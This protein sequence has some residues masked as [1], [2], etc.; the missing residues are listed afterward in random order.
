M[1]HTDI[2]TAGRRGGTTA[3]VSALKKKKIKQQ[4]APRLVNTRV[5][6]HEIRCP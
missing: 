1:I 5:P 2:D 4:N 3:A 6:Q